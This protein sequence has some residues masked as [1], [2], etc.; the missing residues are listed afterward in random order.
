MFAPSLTILPSLWIFTPSKQKLHMVLQ[1]ASKHLH[2]GN[3]KKYGNEFAD[4]YL[5][6]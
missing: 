1:D 5:L 2:A 6:D 3:T 4:K